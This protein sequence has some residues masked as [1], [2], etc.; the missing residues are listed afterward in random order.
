MRR[1]L[2][3]TILL[4]AALSSCRREELH[5]DVSRYRIEIAPSYDMLYN[6]PAQ[7]PKLYKVCFYRPGSG[8]LVTECTV[9]ENGGAL[10]NLQAGVYDAIVYDY[11]FNR[12]KVA[13]NGNRQTLR[14]YS[15][16]VAYKEF[17]VIEA[18][19]HLFVQEFKGLSIPHISDH[20]PEFVIRSEPHSIIDAWCLNV[21]GIKGLRNADII[22]IYI[23]GQTDALLFARDGEKFSGRDVAIWF[24]A[25]CDYE[26]GMI[27]TPFNTF[28]KMSGSF[29]ELVLNMRIVGAGGDT[30]LCRADVTDQFEDPHNLEHVI[31]ASFDITINERKDGGMAPVTDIWT[32]IIEDVTLE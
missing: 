20:D 3:L 12:T 32:P 5:D 13:D 16:P 31:S 29:S 14:A 22:D 26:Q 17:P 8:E 19:D 2:T 23:T 6:R 18:P 9:G 10:Y 24:E 7:T 11:T 1:M 15:S 21:D 28:G 30:Y 27:I 25:V 4:A